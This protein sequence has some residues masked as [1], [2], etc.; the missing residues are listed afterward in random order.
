MHSKAHSPNR[1]FD[2]HG[3][4]GNVAATILL[5]LL[6]LLFLFLFL[7]L[8]AP[9]L[10][11]QNATP[12]TARQAVNMPQFAARLAR[13]ASRTPHGY[14]PQASYKNHPGTR[15]DGLLPTDDIVY[16][17]GPINGTTDAWTI[18]FGF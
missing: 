6:F 14:R 1:L 12:A 15:T 11:A 7:T 16:D 2:M 13:N 3:S 5:M 4:M 18:N 8:A 17:N 10:Q 9:Q